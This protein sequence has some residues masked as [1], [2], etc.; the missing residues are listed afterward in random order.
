MRVTKLDAFGAYQMLRSWLILTQKRGLH[1]NNDARIITTKHNRKLLA[2][3][4]C[5]Q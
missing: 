4:D 2:M 3:I 1:S 5:S